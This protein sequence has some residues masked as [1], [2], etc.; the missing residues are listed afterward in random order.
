[1]TLGLHIKPLENNWSTSHE[2]LVS[3]SCTMPS[4]SKANQKIYVGQ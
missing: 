4:Q 1:L 2:G 3:T